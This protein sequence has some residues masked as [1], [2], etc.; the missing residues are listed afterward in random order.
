[1]QW[2]IGKIQPYWVNTGGTALL[3]TMLKNVW[4]WYKKELEQLLAGKSIP[5]KVN[6]NVVY[7]KN[8]WK[9]R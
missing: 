4:K 2:M 8:R 3:E 9:Q 6:E 7:L 5:V 1:M